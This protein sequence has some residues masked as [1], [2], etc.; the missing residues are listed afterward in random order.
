M[1]IILSASGVLFVLA[2]CLPALEFS[3]SQGTRDIL[4]GANVLAV[5]WSGIFAGVVA[6]YAN[7]LW[8]L[9]MIL[10]FVGKPKVAAIV[11]LVAFATACSTFSLFGKQLPADEGDVQH[12]ALVRTL[13]G[14]Y[15][16]MASLASLPL[17]AF[18]PK[19]K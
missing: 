15:V 16:W 13:I 17:A 4:F 12:M 8:L 9:G 19:V 3:K 6:W 7:P 10:G 5:G 18:F 11:G 14:C 1:K 2:C